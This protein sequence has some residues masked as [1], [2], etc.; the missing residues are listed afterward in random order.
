[1]LEL[2]LDDFEEALKEFPLIQAQFKGLM[3]DRNKW[4]EVKA[5]IKA[6]V[7]ENAT[8][9]HFRI[10]AIYFIGHRLK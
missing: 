3:E 8:L 4:M 1:M 10:W 5:K 9:F 7:W 6:E 2:S